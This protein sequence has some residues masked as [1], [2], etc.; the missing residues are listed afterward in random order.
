MRTQNYTA[1][2]INACA[3]TINAQ[4]SA[5]VASRSVYW[6]WGVSRKFATLYNEMPALGMRVSGLLHKGYVYV[7][8]NE[9][10]DLYE[11]YAVSIRGNVKK[12]V[13][14]VFCDSLGAILDAVIEKDP[15]LTNEAYKV[16]AL[17]DSAR[18]MN[19]NVI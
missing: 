13:K 16:K 10:L 11:I 19:M 14:D 8:Y 5:S 2:E 18:K 3:R 4:I 7:C 6:S 1:A 9:G 15:S 17:R 12:A